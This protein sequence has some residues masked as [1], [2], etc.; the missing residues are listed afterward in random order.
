MLLVLNQIQN[1][2]I[3]LQMMIQM[4]V[5]MKGSLTV[6]E[7]KQKQS[8]AFQIISKFL[9]VCIIQLKNPPIKEFR[10]ICTA[11]Q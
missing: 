9:Y 2:F 7:E 6:T 4:T 5:Q 3:S 8:I 10:V 1:D 11:K